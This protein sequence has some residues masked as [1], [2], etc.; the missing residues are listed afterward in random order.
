MMPVRTRDQDRFRRA[1]RLQIAAAQTGDRRKAKRARRLMRQ[2][3]QAQQ[4][5]LRAAFRSISR[6][7]DIAVREVRLATEAF[8]RQ[9]GMMRTPRQP[10]QQEIADIVAFNGRLGSVFNRARDA[11]IDRARRS[12][13][14][15][16]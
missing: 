5:Q 7:V 4:A 15:R 9:I 13:S 6:S 16:A 12:A 2:L 11:A 8:S 10:T 14:E 3:A 1:R